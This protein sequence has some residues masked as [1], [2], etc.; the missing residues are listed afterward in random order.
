[1]TAT[2]A[3]PAL[4]A[5]ELPEDH[6]Q[7]V[8]WLRDAGCGGNMSAKKTVK[9]IRKVGADKQRGN[10]AKKATSRLTG[11]SHHGKSQSAVKSASKL[12][13]VGGPHPT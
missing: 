6:S 13:I 7:M 9:R 11:K 1:M 12:K 10:S 4:T 3:Q 8:G 5:D 2:A